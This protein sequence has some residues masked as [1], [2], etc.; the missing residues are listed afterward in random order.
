MI[1]TMTVPLAMLE[2]TVLLKGRRAAWFVN[3]ARLPLSEPPFV[4]LVPPVMFVLRARK[5]LARKAS[6]AMVLRL[7]KIAARDTNV[8]EGLTA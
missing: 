5:A 7:A 3:S 6:T 4:V 1:V 8:L 2:I